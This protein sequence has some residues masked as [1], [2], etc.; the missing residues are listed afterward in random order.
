MKRY[1]VYYSFTDE[2]L[3]VWRV[4]HTTQNHD[5]YGFELLGE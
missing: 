1:W 5:V 4:F 2:T 3:T